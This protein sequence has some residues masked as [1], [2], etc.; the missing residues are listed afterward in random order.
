MALDPIHAFYC[1]KAYLDLAQAMKIKSDGEC[2]RCHKIFNISDL[3]PHHKIELTIENITDTTITLNPA[4][5]EVICHDCHNQV[6]QRFNGNFIKH[7]VFIVHGSPLAGKTSYVEQVATRNDLI[8]DLDKLHTAIALCTKYTKPDPTK[9]LAFA[10]RDLLID[11]I[12]TRQGKWFN[13]YVI[14]T[15]PERYDRERLEKELQAELIHI[16]TPQT[17]CLSRCNSIESTVIR[18]QVS[19]WIKEYWRRFTE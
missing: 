2:A 15:Y 14:G 3:R 13:A 18:E 1:T 7:E 5:I 19:G 8:V 4:N 9:Q 17:E 10:M 11:R 12:R 16:N 6:H